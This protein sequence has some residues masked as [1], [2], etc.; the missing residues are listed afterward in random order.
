MPTEQ[1]LNAVMIELK[2]QAYDIIANTE[3]LQKQLTETNN[4]IMELNNKLIQLKQQNLTPP[5]PKE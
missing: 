1:E 2:A 5:P 3:Y 4:K